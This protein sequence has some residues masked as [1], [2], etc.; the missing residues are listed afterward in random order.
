MFTVTTS[1]SKTPSASSIGK[2]ATEPSFRSLPNGHPDAVALSMGSTPINP[3]SST[4]PGGERSV[5]Q[6]SGFASTQSPISGWLGHSKNT[7][8]SSRAPSVRDIRIQTVAPFDSSILRM[9]FIRKK[10]SKLRKSSSTYDPSLVPT[11]L[12][13]QRIHLALLWQPHLCGEAQLLQHPHE[14]PRHVDL[15]PQQAVPRAVLE[16]VV[17]VVPALAKRQQRHRGVV[18]RDIAGLEALEPPHVRRGV[19]EPRHVVQR[20]DAD[21]AAPDEP[22]EPADGVEEHGGDEGVEGVR[23]AQE[24]VERLL[25]EVGD[26]GAVGED[27]G[28]LLVHHPA[29][30]RPEEAVERGVRVALAVA[31]RVV[32]PV[33]GDPLRG[34]ALQGA[35]AE[36]GEEVLEGLGEDEGAVGEVAVVREGDA[37]AG[38]NV[39][40]EAGEDG[41]GCAVEGREEAAGV[42]EEEDAGD[43]LVLGGPLAVEEAGLGPDVEVP[44]SLGPP[45][46]RPS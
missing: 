19:D 30:V 4:K 23:R 34:V 43:G 5:V 24:A 20:G 39:A 35:G 15:P 2:P 26:V 29:H 12:D 17:V 41:G 46:T 11:K 31:R 18:H 21:E 45:R 40:H 1:G 9:S 27:G 25:E 33:G 42:D 28:A 6:Y 3:S 32:V 22:G 36:P 16:R 14:V 13:R 8:P 7:S 37:E 38:E 10:T 44:E